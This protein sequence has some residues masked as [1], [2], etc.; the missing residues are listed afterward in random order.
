VRESFVNYRNWRYAMVGTAL[1]MLSFVWYVADDP[2]VPPNGGTVLGYTLG[3]AAALLIV[4]L[5]AFG[6]RKRSFN[7]FGTAIGWVSAHIYLGLAAIILATLHCGLR[8]GWNEH[9]LTYVLMVLVT[10]S[11]IWGMYA[12]IRYPGMMSAQRGNQQRKA[13]LAEI[14]EL[15]DQSR[16]IASGSQYTERLISEAVRRTDRGPTS[17]W[18]SLAA[19]DESALLL[20]GGAN[21]PARLVPNPGYS[22]LMDILAQMRLE[23]R[24]PA[25]RGILQQLLELSG[26][27]AVLLGRLRRETQ[28]SAVLRIW[29]WIHVPVCCALL[30]ALVVHILTVFL[31]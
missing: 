19:R 23:S 10:V 15:D 18:A 21:Q 8:F 29:L 16:K 14:D 17:L 25:Q 4:F 30:A 3:T 31:Y 12:Y 5:S 27:K 1:V 28:L 2:R 11:G 13:T 20:G 9:T 7:A 26:K 6:I 24:D 22:T